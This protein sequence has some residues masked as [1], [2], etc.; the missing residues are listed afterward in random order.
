MKTLRFPL[1]FLAV[2]GLA[3]AQAPAT[4]AYLLHV[5]KGQLAT[6][7][8]EDDKTKPEL[9]DGKSPRRQGDEGRLRA[10]RQLRR[11]RRQE[12]ELEA[13][14]R[15]PLRCLQSVRQPGGLGPDRR[16]RPFHQFQHPH[17]PADQAQARQERGQDRHRRLANVNGSAPDLANVVRWYIADVN[18]KGPTV[19]FGDIYL[20]GGARHGIAHAR[21]RGRPATR[22]SA[23][24]SRAR[25]PTCRST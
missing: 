13:I 7:T 1:L 24:A 8:G 20:E 22:S 6:D 15:L 21:R 4:K 2:A 16:S 25:S 18:S 19:T 10:G 12:Q 3:S 23:I 14:R 11:P 5:S 9:V 17:R